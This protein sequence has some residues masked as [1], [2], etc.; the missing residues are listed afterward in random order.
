MLQPTHDAPVDQEV[1][2]DPFYGALNVQDFQEV[3]RVPASLAPATIVRQLELAFGEVWRDLAAWRAE[4]E[5]AGVTTLPAALAPFYAEA[6]FARA[7]GHLIPMLQALHATDQA[8]GSDE[9]MDVNEARFFARS[10]HFIN[11]VRGVP[12]SGAVSV[13]V[14]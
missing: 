14:L 4:Q 2:D 9:D 8:G 3:Y 6:V 5:A 10:D 12:V 7:Y 11:Q 1:G 13:S